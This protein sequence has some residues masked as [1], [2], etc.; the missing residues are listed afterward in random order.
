MQRQGTQ[1]RRLGGAQS[2]SYVWSGEFFRAHLL[3]VLNVIFAGLR[4]KQRKKWPGRFSSLWVMR[5]DSC[6][7]HSLLLLTRAVIIR[8]CFLMTQLLKRSSL[9]SLSSFFPNR[10]DAI[11]KTSAAKE[12][13]SIVWNIFL[14]K[15]L[16]KERARG[17]GHL[18]EFYPHALLLCCSPDREYI[19]GCFSLFEVRTAKRKTNK[20]TSTRLKQAYAWGNNPYRGNVRK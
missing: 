13:V 5:C 4:K 8:W 10:E 15:A 14:L 16:L 1:N 11:T 2:A 6:E 7:G 19:T 3:F 9:S 17:T 20:Q 18:L 12:I